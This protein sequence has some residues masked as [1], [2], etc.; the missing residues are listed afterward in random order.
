MSIVTGEFGLRICSCISSQ[1]SLGWVYL[2]MGVIIGSAV[3]PIALSLFW[4]RLNGCAMMSGAIGGAVLGVI[5]WLA[6][7]AVQPGGL[8]N[9]FASTGESI[10]CCVTSARRSLIRGNSSRLLTKIIR[11]RERQEICM[12]GGPWKLSL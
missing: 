2:F 6:V 10:V 4:S 3:V 12:D 7:A 11:C 9:F 5:S 8:G 1:V